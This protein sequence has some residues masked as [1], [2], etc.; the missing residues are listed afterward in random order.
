MW[1]T[2]DTAPYP[3]NPKNSPISFKRK[4]PI[5]WARYMANFRELIF[6]TPTFFNPFLNCQKKG[7]RG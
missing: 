3:F 1:I 7:L 4:P 5:L 6:N 2:L